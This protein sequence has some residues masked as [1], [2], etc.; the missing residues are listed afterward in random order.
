MEAGVVGRIGK[1]VPANGDRRWSQRGGLIPHHLTLREFRLELIGR[2]CNV[3][4]ESVGLTIINPD[5]LSTPTLALITSD[6]FARPLDAGTRSSDEL[7]SN[8]ESELR[9]LLGLHHFSTNLT[10]S[11]G[12]QLE[13]HWVWLSAQ[14][15]ADGHSVARW[16]AEGTLTVD[17]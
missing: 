13:A 6:V 8:L 9:T 1:L 14:R 3:E 4:F 16:P 7:S 17:L 12:E 2:S 5:D 10:W 15:T 11:Y